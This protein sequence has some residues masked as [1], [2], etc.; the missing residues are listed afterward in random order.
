M[1]AALFFKVIVMN[2]IVMCL[3]FI[4]CTSLFSMDSAITVKFLDE[5]EN[6][7]AE[8]QV[9]KHL[10]K[11]HSSYLKEMLKDLSSLEVC[12]PIYEVSIETWDEV[13][14]LWTLLDSKEKEEAQAA[15]SDQLAKKSLDEMIQLSN[16]L[17]YLNDK[18]MS[19]MSAIASR[20]ADQIQENPHKGHEPAF[21]QLNPRAKRL[22]VDSILLEF[23]DCEVFDFPNFD[24]EKFPPDP[25]QRLKKIPFKFIAPAYATIP[26][27]VV[28]WKIM[29]SHRL[30]KFK[31]SDDTSI[32]ENKI[33]ESLDELTKRKI[34]NYYR[35][36]YDHGGCAIL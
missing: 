19:V 24:W 2:K 16:S 9:P 21:Q 27:A 10:L 17:D 13:E 26:Q 34:T 8:K 3:V 18:K 23:K 25:N 6:I 35:V 33:F 31:V 4:S 12:I 5:D 29:S 30:Q 14:L 36:R 28:L 15:I 11:S 32:N 7:Q 20:L 1:V 22:V